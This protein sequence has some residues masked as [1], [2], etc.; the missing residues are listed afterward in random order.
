MASGFTTVAFTT[1]APGN[2]TVL[3]TLGSI[4]GAVIIEMTAG[5]AVWFQTA[6][7]DANNIYLVASDAGLTG[8][9]VIYAS[10]SAAVNPVQGSSTIRLQDLVDDA[11]NFGD[12]APVLATG[13]SSDQ[14]AIS[15][16]NDVM[17]LI[18]NG[19]PGSKP[20]NWKWNRF[21]LP[22]FPIISYQQDYFIPG[23]VRLGWLESAWA[24]NINQTSIPKQ[25]VP[26]EVHKDLLVTYQQTGYPG[27]ICWIPNNMC[28]TGTW[29]AQP[30]GPTVGYP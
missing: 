12:I 21:N 29:G 19:G 30:Q 13:G 11:S 25:I 1:S 24:S 10:A 22:P 16:A 6:R 9:I 20:F 8:F 26:L 5:G 15:I 23:L 7:Y 14:P 3:N 4:P 27:K 17:Q 2:F 18:I 28:N